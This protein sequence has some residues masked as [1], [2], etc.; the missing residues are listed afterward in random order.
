MFNVY[1]ASPSLDFTTTFPELRLY[2]A[3]KQKLTVEGLSQGI[4]KNNIIKYIVYVYDKN[5]PYRIKYKDITQRK[6]R[7]VIDAGFELQGNKFPEHIEDVLQGRNHKVCD[8][9]IAFLKLHCDINYQHLVMLETMYDKKMKE[10][11][12]G[13]GNEK[14]KELNDIK[15]S[16]ETTQ[17]ELLTHDQ[18]KGLVISLYKSIIS[19]K[20]EMAPEDIALKIKKDGIPKTVSDL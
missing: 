11:L 7:A 2:D 20:L 8:M 15:T 9:I 1:E 4:D 13:G 16:L 17:K 3:F 6:V 18:D 10:V 19:D 5:S 12:L 14:V